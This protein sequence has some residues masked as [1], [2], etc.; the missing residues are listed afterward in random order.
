MVL[1]TISCEQTGC[2][3]TACYREIALNSVG[4][5][6]ERAHPIAK[7]VRSHSKY[8]RKYTL[9]LATSKSKVALHQIRQNN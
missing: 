6:I 5:A 7:S 9:K 8:A 4:G 2:E 3:Q 1:R